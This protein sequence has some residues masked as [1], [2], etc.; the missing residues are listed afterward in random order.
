MP[1]SEPTDE[2]HPMRLVVLRTGLTPDLL[3]AWEKRYGVVTPVRSHGGQRLYSDADVERLSLLARAVKGG[4]AIGQIAKLPLRELQRI[5]EKDAIALS[6]IAA[7]ASAIAIASESRESIHAAA[8]AAV[9]RFDATELEFTLRGAAMRLGMDEMLDGV[10]GPLLLTIGSHWHAGLLSPAHEH[11]ATAVVRRTLTWM[12]ENGTPPPMAPAIVVATLAGQTHE[13][14]A[15]LAAAAA[16]SHGWRVVYLGAN[17]P[18]RDIAVAANHARATAV[19]LSLLHPTE[20]P[21]I[22]GALRDLRAALPASTAII[23]GGTAAASYAP[24]LAAVGASQL[25]S[26]RELRAW[27]RGATKTR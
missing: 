18:A 22:A 2:R 1:Q 8:L 4:R 9:E 13:L 24:A 6:V 23:A 21:T 12:M 14:G 27:L 11:L 5:V 10:I 16:S 15:M 20:D 17:L 19:A 3:R 25:G 7:P 26:I